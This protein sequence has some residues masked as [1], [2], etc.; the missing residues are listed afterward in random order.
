MAKRKFEEILEDLKDQVDEDLFEELQGF[1]GSKLRENAEKVPELERKL[2][3]AEAKVT[4]LEAGPA[5]RKAFEEYGIDFENL[6]KAER[7][8]LDEYEGELDSEEIGKLA[9]EFDLPTVQGADREEGEEA[10]EAERQAQQALGRNQRTGR[11]SIKPEDTEDWPHDKLMNF[12]EK[13]P[14]EYEALMRGETVT[15]V[16]A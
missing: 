16:P 10:P 12:M 6:S 4:K 9:E 15:G 3:E 2:A 5:K 14:D 7:R 11:L 1:S 8:I 13:H